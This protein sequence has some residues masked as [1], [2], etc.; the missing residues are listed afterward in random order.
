MNPG[1]ELKVVLVAAALAVIVV[2]L[3]LKKGERRRGV[4]FA[5]A[6]LAPG[7]G[8]VVLGKWAKGLFF[9]VL[10]GLTYLA[11][12]YIV[13]FR[14]V[15]FD[16][17]PFYYVG[18]YGSGLTFLLARVM[19]EHKAFPR[20]ELH[21]SWFDPG[22]LYVCVAGLLNVVIM[23]NVLDLRVRPVAAAA[24]APPAA[25]PAAEPQATAKAAPASGAE[26]AP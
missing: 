20:P 13:G 24:P 22:L 2:N 3:S 9:F 11:G 5:A 10:L 21:P 7:A 1:T 19:S 4:A 16:D 18:Q 8:H 26:K 17:N 15:S 25:A 12:L 6:W 23:M 14:T